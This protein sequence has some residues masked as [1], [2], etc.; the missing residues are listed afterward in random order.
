MK[1]RTM[2]NGLSIPVLGTGTNTFGKENNSF[3]GRITYDTTELR[4][5]IELGYRL[6]DTAIYYRNE[7]VIGKAVKES[8]IARNEFF[9]TSKIP[10]EKEYTETDELVAHYVEHSLELLDMDY[11]DLYLIHFPLESN[12]ENVRIWR[13]LESYVDKGVLKSIG[14]SNFNEEQLSYLLEHARIK[15]VLN[16]FQ[17]YPGKHQQSLIDFCKANDIIPEAYQSFA[18]L[19][20]ETK[21]VL[22]E[23]STSYNKTW[24]QII[25]NYQIHEGLVVIPKSHSKQHQS[26]NIDVFD[27]ELSANDTKTIRNL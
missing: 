13:V 22:K 11:I 18:K 8:G 24:S 4:S 1:Y 19:D 27:F 14:V 15:P 21:S 7:A 12:Q 5:A 25:L 23:I 3:N 16:Q 20:D 17:S 26:E 9:I 6:I 10:P 2:N